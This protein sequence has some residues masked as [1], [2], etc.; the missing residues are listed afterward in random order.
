M[1]IIS[2]IMVLLC[3]ILMFVVKRECKA[4]LLIVG[5]ILFTLVKVPT[6]PFHSANMLLSLVFLLSEI[7]NLP[8]L[9]KTAKKSIV[10]KLMGVA[11][12][13]FVITV[14]ASPH[15]HDFAAIRLF[16][17][18]E[19]FFKYFALLYAFWTFGPEESIRPT[20]RVTFYAML[21]LTLFGFLNLI[22]KSADFVNAMMAGNDK[23]IILGGLAGNEAGQMF[24]EKERFRVQ[25]MFIN[26]FDYG[27]ACILML[28]LHI[29]GFI[30]KYEKKE[31]FLMVVICAVFG[32]VFCGCRTNIFCALIGMLVF[33][34]FAFKLKKSIRLLL[35]FVSVAVLCYFYIP[36]VQET[37][38]NMMTM[39][40]KNSDVS[41]SSMEMRTLQYAAVLY[42]VQDNPMFGCGYNYFNIDL[43]W[44][45]GK[46]YLLDPRLA[47]LEGV[48][49]G[50]I[51]ERGFVG[52][53]LYFLFYITIFIYFIKNRKSSPKVIAFGISVLCIYLTFANMTGELLSVYPTLLLLGYVFKVISISR[54]ENI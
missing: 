50:Y 33:F 32:I 26:P 3:C 52:L 12:L 23:S 41:G 43:G 44:G 28:L 1:K 25:A 5:T 48:V 16:F 17:Q 49:M 19:L 4:S 11:L 38:D 6:I 39:F 45:Q 37:V 29:Y 13:M 36:S 51:L 27:Y 18:S 8:K 42:H 10:W 31:K 46:E 21:I 34:L 22:T 54:M 53:F 35:I 15:L 20:L 2:I 47:G 40:D 30:N 14:L 7:G 24:A 9:M